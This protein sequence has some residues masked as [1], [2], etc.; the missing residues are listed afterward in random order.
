[1]FRVKETVVWATDLGGRHY[2][3]MQ[4]M[5]MESQSWL[6]ADTDPSSQLSQCLGVSCSPMIRELAIPVGVGIREK[7]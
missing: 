4:M 3:H 6:G 7:G 1:M 2:F 5:A